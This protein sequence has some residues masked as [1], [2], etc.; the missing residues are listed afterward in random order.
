VNWR[1]RRAIA[2]A[3]SLLYGHGLPRSSG[4]SIALRGTGSAPYLAL[5]SQG[6]HRRL[7][8]LHCTSGDP[9]AGADR[10]AADRRLSMCRG[11]FLPL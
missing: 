4:R 1:D 9:C 3:A 7:W 6:R 10:R 11:S 5:L 8:S 2:V